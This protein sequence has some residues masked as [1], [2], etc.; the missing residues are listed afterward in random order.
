MNTAY[1]QNQGLKIYT[2]LLLLS[3]PMQ[4]YWGGW[5]EVEAPFM[6]IST[7]L[8]WNGIGLQLPPQTEVSR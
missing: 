2:V 6:N 1:K 3:K 4:G 5:G 7:I 8:V